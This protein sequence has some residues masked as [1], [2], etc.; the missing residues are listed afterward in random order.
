LQSLSKSKNQLEKFT[1][2]LQQK[3]QKKFQHVARS[4]RTNNSKG[5]LPPKTPASHSSSNFVK[6][7]QTIN[8]HLTSIEKQAQFDVVNIDEE[9]ILE[10]RPDEL[11]KHCKMFSN[12]QL[13]D[14]TAYRNF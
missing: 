3:Q 4:G 5:Q 7:T 2:V 9:A 8:N 11:I 10:N 6:S 13:P 14:T 1:P 12:Q